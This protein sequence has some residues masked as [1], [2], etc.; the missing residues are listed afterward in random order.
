MSSPHDVIDVV[1]AGRKQ[2]KTQQ[3][4]DGTCWGVGW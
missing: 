1:I 4:L 3:V 2:K